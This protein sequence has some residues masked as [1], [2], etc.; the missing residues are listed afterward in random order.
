MKLLTIVM[1]VYNVE[2]YIKQAL[3]S[4]FSQENPKVE[5]IVVDDGSPDSSYDIIVENYQ[6]KITS[7][8]FTLLRQENGGVSRARNL[9]LENASGKYITFFDSDDM[10][11]DSYVESVLSA[12]QTHSPDVI[13]FGFKTFSQGK[14]IEQS[15]EVFVYQKFG[16]NDASCVRE[17]IYSRS[18]WYPWLRVIKREL[19][20]NKRFPDGVKFCEDLMLFTNIYQD[21]R[22]IYHIDKALYGY[23][24]NQNG[25]T[26]NIKPDYF[27][28]LISF[29]ASLNNVDERYMDYLK[30]NLA[31]L[32]Y[33]CHTGN[34]VPNK[35]R[36]EFFKLFVRYMFDSN[37]S[38]RKKIILVFPNTHR[39]L[40]RWLKK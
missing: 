17:T 37:V 39:T 32:F 7:G 31:Y 35:I 18:V 24:L 8:A 19:F 16:L 23:R 1:P 11:L 20:F 33:R 30:I 40:K 12:I 22:S 26:L 34:K 27:D 38:Y 13:E 28:N 4:Y 25:A 10:L 36:L 2:D 29:Y 15:P 3:D 21:V 14:S 5:L 6:D 9:A